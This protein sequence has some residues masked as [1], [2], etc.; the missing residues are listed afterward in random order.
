MPEI[1][2]G[3]RRCPLRG[4]RQQFGDKCAF[5][6]I[7]IRSFLLKNGVGSICSFSLIPDSFISVG[8]LSLPPDSDPSFRES[9]E[10][11]FG[12]V[13]P[14]NVVPVNDKGYLNGKRQIF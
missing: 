10:P 3:G 6:R 12:P 8:M 14:S 11:F 2:A 9:V 7:C 4:I 13:I 5:P 1:S